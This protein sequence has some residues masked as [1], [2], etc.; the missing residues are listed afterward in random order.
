MNIHEEG[1]F[2]HNDGEMHHSVKWNIGEHYP[3]WETC[4]V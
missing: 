4:S 3:V 2:I 1:K